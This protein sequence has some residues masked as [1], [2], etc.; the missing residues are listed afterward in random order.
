MLYRL[1]V[2]ILP[3]SDVDASKAFYEKLGWHCDVDHQA[4]PN[5]RIVQ[6]TPP[7][8]GCSVLF[9]IG[10]PI[11]S[12]P[13]TFQGMHIVVDDIAEASADFDERGIDYEGPFYFGEAGQ[14]DGVHPEHPDYGSYLAFTDPDGNRWLVQ[15]VPSRQGRK[16]KLA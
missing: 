15:E 7:G 6:F 5:F 10:M 16:W 12:Q 11:T 2:F 3:V 8:S 4:G 14:T 9:G 1:E 13:G